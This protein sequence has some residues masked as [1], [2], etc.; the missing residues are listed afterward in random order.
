MRPSRLV[1]T[2]VVSTAAVLALSGCNGT[3]NEATTLEGLSPVA[4][5]QRVA[6]NASNDSAAY[7]FDLTGSGLAVSGKGAYRGGEDPAM[8]MSFDSLKMLGLGS[9]GGME[10]RL[11][12][13]VMYIK[14]AGGGLLGGLGDG[15]WVKLPADELKSEGANLGGLDLT[16]ADPAEQLKKMLDTE[17]VRKV[18]TETMDGVKTTHYAAS[19][20]P[21]GSG[22]VVE[23]RSESSNELSRELE[24][25]LENSIRESMGVDKPVQVDV[26]V[27]EAYRARKMVMDLPFFGSAT[28][29]MK[30]TDFGK[31]VQV[32]APADAKA[33]D[34]GDL[35]GGSLGSALS[36]GFGRSSGN[37]SGKEFGD[38]FGGKLDDSGS[39]SE[40]FS[41]QFE[42]K[43]REQIENS[44]NA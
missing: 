1:R 25:K 41:Q 40:D 31:D 32:Q 36:E 3:S 12:D 29:T 30:F 5:I 27:D 42:D 33:L 44:L 14:S 13:D 23:K 34:F 6:D 20:N 35:L 37:S 4:A 21:E 28:M 17:D 22:T 24:N 9:S 10:F 43:L 15:G 19:I 16:M 18:G 11:V 7:T 39:F 8:A 26:W 38:L 2:A